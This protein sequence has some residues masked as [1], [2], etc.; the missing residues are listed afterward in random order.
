M[1]CDPGVDEFRTKWIDRTAIPVM[2][3][4][5]MYVSYAFVAWLTVTAL[6]SGVSP[7]TAYLARRTPIIVGVG[8]TFVGAHMAPKM[9]NIMRH[10]D[11]SSAPRSMSLTDSDDLEQPLKI[12]FRVIFIVGPSGIGKSALLR[13][14]MA[15]AGARFKPV[16]LD[17][18]R[19][20]R[21]ER[22]ASYRIRIGHAALLK[23]VGHRS[24]SC[25]RNYR[26]VP[27]SSRCIGR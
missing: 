5:S 9:M 11:R 10:H 17:E 25:N 7:L 21:D 18:S 8:G 1:R 23:K 19:R 3:F 20:K 27:A 2:M 16:S 24:S 13:K 6:H 15:N 14:F 22:E 26:P 12:D 4:G